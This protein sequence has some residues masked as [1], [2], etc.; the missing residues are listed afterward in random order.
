MRRFERKI[1]FRY[2]PAADEAALLVEKSAAPLDAKIA[3]AC[4][5][6]ATKARQMA[7]TAEVVAPLDPASL[8][9]WA[10]Q[11]AERMQAAAIRYNNSASASLKSAIKAQIITLAQ[12][13]A[14]TTWMPAVVAPDLN[15]VLPIGKLTALKDV[16]RDQFTANL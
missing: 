16:V 15:G 10:S 13:E 7:E 3:Q 14:E 6:V 2:L 4:V 8:I 12:E 9:Y 11:I 5:G 1:E